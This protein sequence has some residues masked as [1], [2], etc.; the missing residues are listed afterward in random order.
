[1]VGWGGCWKC[2]PHVFRVGLGFQDHSSLIVSI[3]KAAGA[4]HSSGPLTTCLAFSVH[5]LPLAGANSS[6]F[7]ISDRH[8][9]T[10]IAEPCTGRATGVSEI[11]SSGGGL[12]Q[13]KLCTLLLICFHLH[14]FIEHIRWQNVLG[15]DVLTC[16]SPNS[17]CF[18]SLTI[19]YSTIIIRYFQEL[20]VQNFKTGI[21]S[22]HFHR[23]A[24]QTTIS[25][26]YLC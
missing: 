11:E 17:K 19:I 15:H 26:P 6:S 9:Q 5:L 20:S 22:F 7:Y 18:S 12:L 1:M 4:L 24:L 23:D 8:C 25:N 2:H 13:F 16:P 10:Q 3:L 21:E 14:L